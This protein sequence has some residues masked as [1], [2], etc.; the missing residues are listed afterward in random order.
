MKIKKFTAPSVPLALRQVHEGLGNQAVILNTRTLEPG[1]DPDLR[2]EITAAL[3]ESAPVAVET[4]PQRQ[5]SAGA[6][7]PA[8]AAGNGRAD[9]LGRVYGRSRPQAA[10]NAAQDLSPMRAPTPRWRDQEQERPVEEGHIRSAA[11]WLAGLPAVQRDASGQASADVV[12]T[13]T[14]T[15]EISEKKD[16]SV[17]IGQLRQLEDAVHRMASQTDGF[18][19]PPELSRIG[20][21][22]RR[23]GLSSA[24]MH[25]CQQMAMRELNN[26]E[27]DDRELVARTVVRCLREMLPDSGEIRIGT[28]QKVVAF[29]GPSGSGKTTAAARIAAGFVRRRQQRGAEPYSGEIVLVNADSQRVGALAQARAFADLIRVPLELAYDEAEMDSAVA[30][31]NGAR[32]VLVDAGGC[33]PHERGGIEQQRRMLS[34][35]SVDEVHVVVDGLTGPDHILETAKTWNEANATDTGVGIETRLVVTKMDQ[36]V[37]PGAIVSAAIDAALPISYLTVSAS[38]PGGICPGDLTPW[39]EWMVGLAPRPFA[40]TSA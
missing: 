22:L 26:E 10:D 39:V 27:L 40:D 18:E 17:V 32:L 4:S 34:A 14:A 3:D 31:H 6:E 29:V 23:T 8:R 9:L 36:C 21:R 35:A 20:E 11:Q 12:D 33:G 5:E 15:P 19:L 2:V 24:H 7:L 30:T 38:I 28:E 1:G 13:P 16:D 37:R 25:Q